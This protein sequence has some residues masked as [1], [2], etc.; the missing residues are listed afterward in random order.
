MVDACGAGGLLTE[1]WKKTTV[2]CACHAKESSYDGV[3]TKSF[4]EALEGKAD[5]NKDGKLEIGEV[6][7][8]VRRRSLTIAKKFME[9]QHPQIHL[10]EGA[11]KTIP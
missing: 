3:T 6:A 4:I 5:A 1:K 8:Y 10:G 2:V 9:N 7:H 11:K